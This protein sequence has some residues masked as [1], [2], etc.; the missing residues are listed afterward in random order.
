LKRSAKVPHGA[1]DVNGR[2]KTHPLLKKG[3]ER[4][5]AGGSTHLLLKRLVC[6]IGLEEPDETVAWC[7]KGGL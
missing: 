4:Q 2:R 6:I 7:Q 5:M 3:E 1:E